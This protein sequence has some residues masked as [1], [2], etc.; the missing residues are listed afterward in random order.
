MAG[1]RC[2]KDLKKIL[3]SHQNWVGLDVGCGSGVWHNLDL[4]KG[5]GQRLAEYGVDFARRGKKNFVIG[6]LYHLPFRDKTFD[7]VASAHVGEHLEK[8]VEAVKEMARITKHL[9]FANIPRYTRKVEET[10]GCVGLDTYYY[11]NHADELTKEQLDWF[12]IKFQSKADKKGV[13]VRDF[14]GK[15]W[16]KAMYFGVKK[17]YAPHCNWYPNPKDVYNLFEKTGCFR[18]IHSEVGSSCGES[19]T[20]GWLT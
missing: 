11:A 2:I 4:E 17:R 12:A 20:C 5:A 9:V 14:V 10:S 13:S 6:S 1:Y 3:Q 18:R 16:G 19:N 7:Y 8:P 15:C